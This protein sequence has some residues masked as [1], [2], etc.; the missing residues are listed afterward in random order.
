MKIKVTDTNNEHWYI[1]ESLKYWLDQKEW[2]RFL[3]SLEPTPLE[4]YE[5]N[6]NRIFKDALNQLNNLE[7]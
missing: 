5:I 1:K 3:E 4:S 7:L 6:I 2:E